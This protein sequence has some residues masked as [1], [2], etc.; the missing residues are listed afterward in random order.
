MKHS[1][2]D[3][4]GWKRHVCLYPV[5]IGSNAMSQPVLPHIVKYDDLDISLKLGSYEVSVLYL[6]YTPVI[7]M[8]MIF[9]HAHS[10]YELHFVPQGEGVLHVNNQRH[11]LS[12]GSFYVT[13]PQ[14]YHMQKSTAGNPMSEYC[15]NL[16]FKATATAADAEWDQVIREF[17]G[18]RFHL[19]GDASA[20]I[21][22]FEEIFDELKKKRSG[23]FE[24]VKM[25]AAMVIIN[26]TRLYT[27]NRQSGYDAPVKTLDTKRR[28]IIEAYFMKYAQNLT[29]EELVQRV[30]VGARQLDRI[31][32]QYFGMGFKEKLLSCR[33]EASLTYLMDKGATLESVSE[34]VGYEDAYHYAKTFKH[35]YGVS[36]MEYRRRLIEMNSSES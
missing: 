8:D 20:S 1:C 29:P 2:Y 18:T 12:A 13:G 34:K 25:L 9:N 21:R 31:L 19:S 11:E 17:I 23:Y 15:M 3:D 7:A 32:N 33:L 24:M 36:P 22:L 6:R 5:L 4:N 35:R 10:S 28:L 14:V 16:E 30:G 27:C 26:C